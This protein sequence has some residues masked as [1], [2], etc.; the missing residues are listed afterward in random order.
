MGRLAK[1]VYLL[2]NGNEIEILLRN[3]S[4]GYLTK[5]I[6]IEVLID[7]A[8]P[9]GSA[10]RPSVVSH[11][12]RFCLECGLLALLEHLVTGTMAATRRAPSHSVWPLMSRPITCKEERRRLRPR[13]SLVLL[14]DKG[15]RWYTTQTKK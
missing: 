13:E 8:V 9:G 14:A 1:K 12:I 7:M 2:L 6:L 11:R 10:R 4:G 15:L 5:G 3:P